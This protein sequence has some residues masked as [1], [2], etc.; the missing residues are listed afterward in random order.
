MKTIK[1]IL[2]TNNQILISQIEEVSAD[3]GEPECKLTEPFLVNSD[4]TL[5]P[6]LIEY[7][8]QNIYMISSEKIM[9]IADP[10]PTLIEKYENLIK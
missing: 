1:L 6:W 8:S 3:L 4:N 10:K 9:T 7:T 2:L 5:T